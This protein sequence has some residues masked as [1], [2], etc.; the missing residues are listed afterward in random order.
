M[1]VFHTMFDIMMCDWG[2]GGRYMESCLPLSW[3]LFPLCAQHYRRH[4]KAALPGAEPKKK[5]GTAHAQS[6]FHLARAAERMLMRRNPSFPPHFFFFFFFVEQM[7]GVEQS[8][9]EHFTGYL[10]AVFLLLLLIWLGEGGRGH[11]GEEEGVG[12]D[13]YQ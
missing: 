5:R 12:V 11:L 2:G 7:T 1:Y 3:Q 9:W 6:I 10:A 4:L 13:P 8:V